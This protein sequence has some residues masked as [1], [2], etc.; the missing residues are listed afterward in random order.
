MRLH[1]VRFLVSEPSPA[2]PNQEKFTM[3]D[4]LFG[5]AALLLAGLMTWGASVIEES[6]IQDP[7]G[8]K[9]FP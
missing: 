8:P 5:L 9:A 4:R 6:F 1:G 3:T 2:H 7:L